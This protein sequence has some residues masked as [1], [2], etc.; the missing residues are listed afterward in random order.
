MTL[1]KKPVVKYGPGCGLELLIVVILIC[2]VLFGCRSQKE[3]CWK[4]KEPK[5]NNKVFN[6]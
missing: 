3:G 2:V 1:I 4:G 6:K 5:Y